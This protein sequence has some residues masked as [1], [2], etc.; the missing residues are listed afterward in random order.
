MENPT[1][2]LKQQNPPTTCTHACVHTS[3]PTA[4]MHAHTN[5]HTCKYIQTPAYRATC[6]NPP[7]HS[8][9]STPPPPP[10]TP[11]HPHLQHEPVLHVQHYLLPLLVVSEEGVQRVRVGTH[12]ISPGTVGSQSTDGYCR[13]EI[14]C[15]TLFHHC[16]T[17]HQYCIKSPT[18]C[19]TLPMYAHF[20]AY[21]GQYI[22][23]IGQAKVT[24]THL[25]T[26]WRW[27][28]L[29]LNQIFPVHPKAS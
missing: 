3:T 28:S 15:T 5:T 1:Y 2:V 6:S 7:S 19:T 22:P 8:S 16:I 18:H 20:P 4:G 10:P 11:T 29:Y 26:G 23:D 25:F 14:H 17:P 21:R 9:S 27:S 12:P 24:T 13:E